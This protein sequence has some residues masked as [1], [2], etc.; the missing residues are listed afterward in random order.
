MQIGFC[1]SFPLK[2]KSVDSGS[3]TQLTKVVISTIFHFMK[4]GL[5]VF[6]RHS[7]FK[8]QFVSRLFIR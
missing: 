3:I 2:M 6:V 4:W 1:L 5:T 7:P 8:R